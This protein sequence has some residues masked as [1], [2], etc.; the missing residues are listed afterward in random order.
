MLRERRAERAAASALKVVAASDSSPEETTGLPAEELLRL[1]DG[2]P[3]PAELAELRALLQLQ[4]SLA[5][6]AQ[7]E[8]EEEEE[9]DTPPG[10]STE[11]ELR[12]MARLRALSDVKAEYVGEC[13]LAFDD[14][15]LFLHDRLLD[16]ERLC[17]Q[18]DAVRRR[19]AALPAGRCRFDESVTIDDDD[20]D[21]KQRVVGGMDDIKS[22]LAALLED[23]EAGAWC[24]ADV[25]L[26]AATEAA[27][28]ADAA[29]SGGGDEEEVLDQKVAESRQQIKMWIRARKSG[30]REPVPPVLPPVRGGPPKYSQRLRGEAA[31]W[32]RRWGGEQ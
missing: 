1:D 23:E 4:A 28:A 32:Q 27:D 29:D 8:E 6:S 31:S 14:G 30:D 22:E 13:L 9:A 2:T 16:H 7:R 12:R 20:D 19:S 5:T 18:L 10:G 17:R 11:E 26:D 15:L 25:A 3:L 21:G 24:K